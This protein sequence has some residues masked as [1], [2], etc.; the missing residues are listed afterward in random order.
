ME[1]M[2]DNTK[3]ILYPKGSIFRILKDDIISAEFKVAKG[4]IA[5]AVSDIEVNDKYAEVCC[6][7]GDVR[8]RNGYYG[9]YSYQRPHRKQIGEK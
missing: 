9:Y 1:K 8:Y 2:D 5:E 3:N 4:A 7:G 6:N